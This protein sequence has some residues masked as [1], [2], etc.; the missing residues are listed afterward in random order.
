LIE[1]DNTTTNTG[2]ML[3]L[4]A[5]TADGGIALHY[6]GSANVGYMTFHVDAGGGANSE[7][8]RIDSSGN[9]LVGKTTSSIASRRCRSKA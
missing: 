4:R 1:N 2:A 7:R 9:V 8:M 3:G 5:D 6:G